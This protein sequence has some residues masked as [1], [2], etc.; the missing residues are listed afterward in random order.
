MSNT[1][2]KSTHFM[3]HE[4]KERERMGIELNEQR[5][6]MILHNSVG[7]L[8]CFCEDSALVSIFFLSERVRVTVRAGASL[9]LSLASERLAKGNYQLT[10]QQAGLGRLV[11]GW[12]VQRSEGHVLVAGGG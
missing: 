6:K 7:F 11:I 2:N 9:S 4:E 10:D 3:I 1:T 12:R 8:L 5:E